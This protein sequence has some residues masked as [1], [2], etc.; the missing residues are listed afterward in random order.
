MPELFKLVSELRFLP[1]VERIQEGDHSIVNRMS[2]YR[3]VT[4]PYVSCSIRMPEVKA[5]K[6]MLSSPEQYATFISKFPEV[7]SADVLA[8]R[9]GF[10]P[11]SSVAS[12]LC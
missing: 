6:A 7:V 12:G 9:F 11:T 8:R 1:V 5:I 10:L 2:Q 3:R 4:G